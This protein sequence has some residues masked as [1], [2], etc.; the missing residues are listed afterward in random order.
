M[1]PGTQTGPGESG[2]GSDPCLSDGVG[3]VP[4][5]SL[6]VRV[7][8]GPGPDVEAARRAAVLFDRAFLTDRV[9]GMFELRYVSA[10]TAKSEVDTVLSGTGMSIDAIQTIAMPPPISIRRLRT[11]PV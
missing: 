9:V 7:R 4:H 3:V 11:P 8:G 6:G 1:V 10:E 5:V 2:S